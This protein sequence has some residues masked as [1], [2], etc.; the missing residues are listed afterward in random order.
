MTADPRALDDEQ[1]DMGRGL[2]VGLL[3]SL[4]EPFGL[5]GLLIGALLLSGECS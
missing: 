5:L 2:G 3:V 4:I 1:R